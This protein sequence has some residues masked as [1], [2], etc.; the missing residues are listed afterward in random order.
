M[1]KNKIY[2]N[3]SKP[4]YVIGLLFIIV[5]IIVSAKNVDKTINISRTMVVSNLAIVEKEKANNIGYDLKYFDQKDQFIHLYLIGKKVDTRIYDV[6]FYNVGD[7]SVEDIKKSTKPNANCKI[8]LNKDLNDATFVCHNQEN[9]ADVSNIL[10]Y[11]SNNKVIN[12]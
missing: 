7:G 3:Q 1:N 11:W 4:F 8:E 5:S 12:K 6:N 9:D 10:D 2:S